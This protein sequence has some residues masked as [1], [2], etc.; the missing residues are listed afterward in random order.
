M[1]ATD[2]DNKFDFRN[3]AN[4]QTEWSAVRGKSTVTAEGSNCR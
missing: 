3:A 4:T 1:Q 2:H